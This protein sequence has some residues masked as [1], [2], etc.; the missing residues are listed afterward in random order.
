MQKWLGHADIRTTQRYV[1]STEKS[2]EMMIAF[3]K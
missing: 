2:Q 3:S 1:D